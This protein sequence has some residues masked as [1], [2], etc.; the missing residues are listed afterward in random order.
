MTTP[1]AANRPDYTQII[2]TISELLSP[3]SK[4]KPLLEIRYTTFTIM[5]RLMG[6]GTGQLV[7]NYKTYIQ[8]ELT[9]ASLYIG[10]PEKQP[11]AINASQMQISRKLLRLANGYSVTWLISSK[12]IQSA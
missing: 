9:D 1:N 5:L 6:V 12:G 4:N 3:G 8:T 7:R 10:I 2:N 11:P